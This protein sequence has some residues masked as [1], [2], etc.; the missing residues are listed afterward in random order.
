MGIVIKHL[1]RIQRIL[2]E[3]AAK[4]AALAE[5]ERLRPGQQAMIIASGQEARKIRALSKEVIIV[6]PG[7]RPAG[8]DR[9]EQK[10]AATPTEAIQAG[11]DYLVPGRPITQASNPRD[12]AMKI[13]EEMQSA[14]DSLRA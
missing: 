11:A 10:R 13:V 5:I 7:I 2:G 12:A 14:F 9:H 1:D 8:A 4:Q 3:I 6:T